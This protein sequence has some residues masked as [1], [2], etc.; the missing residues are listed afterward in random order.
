MCQ[1][2]ENAIKNCKEME[3]DRNFISGGVFMKHFSEE[4]T[5][6]LCL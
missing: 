5:F 3:N 4:V 6:G 2:M 1:I